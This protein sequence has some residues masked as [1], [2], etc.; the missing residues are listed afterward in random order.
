MS[1]LY[2]FKRIEKKYRITE[3]QKN[4]LLGIIGGRL[5][6]DSHG[7]SNIFSLY[8]DTPDR[9]LIRNSIDAKA[10]KEKLRLRSYGIPQA[11]TKIF[12]EIKKKYNGIVYKRRAAMT[13]EDAEQY[14]DSG[15]KP[16]ESQIM[17]EIDYSMNFYSRPEP[18]MMIAYE[19]EAYYDAE[20][21]DLRITFDRDIRYFESNSFSDGINEGTRIIDKNTYIMEIKTGGAMPLWLAHT[22][23]EIGLFPSSFSKY[24]TAYRDSV[25]HSKI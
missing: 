6:P 4:Q 23:N 15:I 20:Y 19:R 2:I 25:S 22:L 11:D 16:F 9:L 5:I 10:Y 18:S 21:P 3:E 13:L 14:I 17:S 24:G 8:L 7:K 1:D 12:F